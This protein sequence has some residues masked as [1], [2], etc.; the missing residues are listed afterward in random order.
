MRGGRVY[1]SRFGSAVQIAQSTL[2][3]GHSSILE[4]CR[5]RRWTGAAGECFVNP[6]KVA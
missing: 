1:E 4:R 6:A 5:T 3:A 2:C